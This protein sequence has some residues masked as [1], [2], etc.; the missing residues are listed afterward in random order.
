ML[1]NKIFFSDADEICDNLIGNNQLFGLENFE[2]LLKILP[3]SNEVKIIKNLRINL[4]IFYL[5]WS[6]E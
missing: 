1:F 4:K 5:D 3:D 6:L 2:A